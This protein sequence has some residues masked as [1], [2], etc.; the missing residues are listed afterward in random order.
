MFFIGS[1][2]LSLNDTLKASPYN[3]ISYNN[4]SLYN[5]IFAFSQYP[6]VFQESL[7]CMHVCVRVCMCVFPQLDLIPFYL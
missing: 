4:E 2:K 1:G 5:D 7:R 3:D 6:L